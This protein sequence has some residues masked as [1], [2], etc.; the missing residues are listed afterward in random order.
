MSGG[1]FPPLVPLGKERP[2]SGR[3]SAAVRRNSRVH[4]HRLARVLGH[5]A[6]VYQLDCRRTEKLSSLP[7]RRTPVDVSRPTPSPAVQTR[8]AVDGAVGVGR[9]D[10]GG[11]RTRAAELR[12]RR[13]RREPLPG[14]RAAGGSG[15]GQRR[16]PV[17]KLAL[18]GKKVPRPR[19]LQRPRIS[20]TYSPT[21]RSDAAV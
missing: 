9:P 12:V 7:A 11:R 16:V 10:S 17:G 14:R 21:I 13:V 15:R 1:G 19:S 18:E 3:R 6:R 2:E 20:R 8:K 4:G 5:D